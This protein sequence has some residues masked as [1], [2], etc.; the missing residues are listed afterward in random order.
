MLPES[1]EFGPEYDLIL[2]IFYHL[3]SELPCDRPSAKQVKL[4]LNKTSSSE[5][6]KLWVKRCQE[7]AISSGKE[8]TVA[9]ISFGLDDSDKEVGT[10]KRKLNPQSDKN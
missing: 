7:T 9:I 8:N 3:T 6:G 1:V 10:K 5:Q 2:E 4:I